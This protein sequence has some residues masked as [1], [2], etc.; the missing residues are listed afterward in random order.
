MKK[1]YIVQLTGNSSLPF[2]IPVTC[3]CCMTCLIF[4]SAGSAVHPAFILQL[5]KF[6][7]WVYIFANYVNFFLIISKKNKS[8]KQKGD[9]RHL[10]P[11][12]CRLPWWRRHVFRAIKLDLISDCK[13]TIEF[14][15]ASKVTF[16]LKIALLSRNVRQTA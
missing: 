5:N 16:P 14:H 1:M 3:L 9:C 11:T 15:V 4:N 7:E 12:M 8:T 10:S 2:Q 13:E 6:N